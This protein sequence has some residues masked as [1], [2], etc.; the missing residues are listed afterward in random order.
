MSSDRVEG[1]VKRITFRNK[2]NGFTVIQLDCGDHSEVTAVGRLP[3]VHIGERL[4]LH[5]KWIQHPQYGPQFEISSCEMLPPENRLGIERYL[6]SGLIPGVGPELA[7]RLVDAFGDDTLDVIVQQPERLQTVEGIG[8]K[9]AAAIT[10]AVSEQ[11]EM[12]RIMVFLQS[13]GLTPGLAARIY[14]QYGA[15][16]IERLREDPYRLAD[17]MFGVGFRRADEIAQAMGVEGDSLQRARAAVRHVLHE[18]LGEGHVYLPGPELVCRVVEFGVS[19]ARADEALQ[20]LA[21]SKRIVVEEAGARVYLAGMHRAETAV[22]EQLALLVAAAEEAASGQREQT[23]ERR[24]PLGGETDGITLSEEQRRAVE[25]AIRSGVCVITGGPGTGKTTVLQALCNELM[26][27]GLKV[28][29]AA[30]TGRAAQRLNEATGRPA[31]TLHRLLEVKHPEAGAGIQFGFHRER[32]LPTDAVIVDE[33]SMIDLP[34]FHHLLQAIRPGTRLVLVGDED[35]LPSVGPGTVLK[36]VLAS[37]RIPV[38]RLT[39]VFRQ[40]AASTIVTNAHRIRRGEI[41][42]SAGEDGDYFF[43][44]CEPDE[45]ADTIVDLV[46]RRLPAYLSCDPLQHIQVLSP[47]RRGAFGV[48][49]LNQQLQAALNPPG[50][51]EVRIG[52]RVLR[53]GDKVMQ[54]RNNYDRMVFNGDI[55]RISR[56]DVDERRVDVV[57]PDADGERVVS[58]TQADLDELTHAFAVSVHK[59]Q[60]SEY[61][62]IVLPVAW[63]MPALMNRNLLYTA[64][65]RAKRLAVFVGQHSALRAFVRNNEGTARYSHLVHRL[66]TLPST[67]TLY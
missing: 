19:E 41:P 20:S 54:I 12:R 38:A 28:E 15:E 35:Q 8:P 66:Q 42:V 5:G 6:A 47:L 4:R 59:S 53:V 1:L 3:G 39:Q 63:I 23:S 14:R 58:Y 26:R 61:P 64:L 45:I 18:A 52:D 7:R 9:K 33:A 51:A 17:E 46:R 48:D 34:L 67:P 36:D 21:Q 2:N 25:L 57:F 60:G 62:C 11:G 55:G 40:A 49:A 32:P 44:R 13:Y 30:P 65:T 27:R 22:A 16:T 43:I 37:G 10:K 31:R 56:I 24:L 50:G 29:L